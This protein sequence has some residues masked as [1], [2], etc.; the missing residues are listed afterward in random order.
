VVLHRQDTY[1]GSV[2]EPWTQNLYTYVGNNPVRYTDPT[3]HKHVDYAGGG[4]GLLLA[5]YWLS[6]NSVDI[7]QT[8]IDTVDCVNGDGLNCAQLVPD[9]AAF[10]AP[11][12]QTTPR[13]NTT[14]PPAK[15][16]LPGGGADGGTGGAS[17]GGKRFTGDQQAVIDLT[18]EQTRRKGGL[19]AEEAETIQGWATEYDL[20][21]RGP[22]AHPDR[23]F[24]QYLHIHVGPLNHVPIIS[25]D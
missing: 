2:W 8:G 12:Q 7:V 4:G 24:G 11:S 9:A 5:Y 16:N 10:V 3:G 17:G 25:P 1:K 23:P 18:R 22:E 21:T 15:G 19:T 14:E 20:G 13:L 6:T